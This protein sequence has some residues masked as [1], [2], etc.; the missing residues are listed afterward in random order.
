MDALLPVE[1]GTDF[2]IKN[3]KVTRYDVDHSIPRASAYLIQAG[4]RTIAYT[5]DM[6]FHG[7]ASS[8]SENFLKACKRAGIDILICEGTRLGPP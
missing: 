5:G 2:E 4:G 6:R 7:N 1:K 3:L 8:D